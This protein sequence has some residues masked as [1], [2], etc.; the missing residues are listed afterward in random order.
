MKYFKLFESF[1]NE[2]KISYSL[3]DLM[4]DVTDKDYIKMC[5]LIATKMGMKPKDIAVITNEDDD[6]GKYQARFR[7]DPSV[8]MNNPSSETSTYYNKRH[9]VVI[10]NDGS[11]I[12]YF[13]PSNQL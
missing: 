7:N 1:V 10:G 12:T 2:A 13:I 9:N 4:S 6:F 5:E 8:A 11:T 3:E